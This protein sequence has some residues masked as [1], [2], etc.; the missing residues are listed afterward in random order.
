MTEA[1]LYWCCF[2]TITW[3][4][5]L[6]TNRSASTF[7]PLSDLYLAQECCNFWFID[8]QSICVLNTSKFRWMLK[9]TLLM[10]TVV[11]RTSVFYKELSHLVYL[12]RVNYTILL[13]FI[14]I[15]FSVSHLH[16]VNSTS[17]CAH[18]KYNVNINNIVICL[19][20]IKE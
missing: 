2:K 5:F 19:L 16:I 17:S 4:W 20:E 8:F 9:L 13:K 12:T 11:F 15:T 1:C 7:Q 14:I 10:C 6:D 3:C 18:W